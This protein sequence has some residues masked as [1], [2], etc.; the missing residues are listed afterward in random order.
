MGEGEGEREKG[1]KARDIETDLTV[2]STNTRA[3][4]PSQ[5]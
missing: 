2:Q 4:L 3:C 5:N 1:G